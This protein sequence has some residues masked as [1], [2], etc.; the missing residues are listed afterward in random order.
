MDPMPSTDVLAHDESNFGDHALVLEAAKDHIYQEQNLFLKDAQAIRQM[1]KTGSGFQY[2]DFDPDG[3]NGEGSVTVK[4]LTRKQVTKDPSA[5][6]LDQCR[7]IIIN[8]AISYDEGMR[9]FPK[10]WEEASTQ[11]MQDLY[12]FAGTKGLREDYNNGGNGGKEADKYASKDISFIEEFWL[13]DYST[14]EIPD[15][16]TQIQLTE[17]SAQLMQGIN[18]DISKW[19]DHAAHLQGHKDQKSI[20]LQEAL[21][22]MGLAPGMATQ[23]DIDAL[24]QDP[25][26]ALILNIIED[27]IEMHQMYAESMDENEIGKRPK[28]PNNLRLIIKTGKVVH[29]DGAP[30]VEDGC[31]PLVEF[32][33]YKDDGPAEGIIKHLIPMQKNINEMDAKEF[34]G[35]KLNANGGWLI[36]EQSGVD[37]D[38]LTDEDGIVVTKQQGTE[39]Q[40]LPSGQVSVQLENRS[41]RDYE[42]MQRIEG[43]GETVFGEAPKSQTS[44]VMYRRL[45]MQALGRIRLKSRMI[46]AAIFRRDK[47]LISRIMKY[48]STERKLRSEDANGSIKFVKF[49]PRMMKDFTYELVLA[50]GT[51][52]GMDNESIAESYKELLLAGAIDLKTY[53]TLTNLPKKQEL[54]KLLSENDQAAAQLQEMQAQNQELQKQMLFL[55]ANMAPQ[56]LAPEEIKMVEQ[57]AIQ[58][59]Q[60]QATQN[61]MQQQAVE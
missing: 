57:L 24:K 23:Q 18:P 8:S 3:E 32:E 45:Q 36:D 44:G 2:V 15:D 55:K 46:E 11:E 37:A 43:A 1:L 51:A 34:K 40:R 48:W 4:N 29:F 5:D 39:V 28:Y 27:H 31:I 9:R 54:L 20:I 13:K 33:C 47:L 58:D 41:R 25:Q 7:Y 26:I 60:A 19:E 52:T 21:A 14:E 53:A 56:L 42:A 49:D 59:A 16:E 12:S 38:T 61:P 50:P 22:T 10:T 6:T 17:E 30:E 35:L